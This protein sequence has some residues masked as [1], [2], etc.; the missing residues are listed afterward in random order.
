MSNQECYCNNKRTVSVDTQNML[1]NRIDKL[2]SMMNKLP[3]Q[4][5]NQNRS[6]K[7]KIDQERRRGQDR[8]N[9]YDRARQWD[10]YR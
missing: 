6:F 7:P 2:T 10:R 1:D 3:I 4:G 5:S 8:Y 9:Y